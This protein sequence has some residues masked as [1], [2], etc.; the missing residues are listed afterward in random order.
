MSNSSFGFHSKKT[1]HERVCWHGSF[2]PPKGVNHRILIYK[3]RALGLNQIAINWFV[4][5]LRDREQIVDI[6]G[7]YSQ[8][9]N[10]TCGVPQRSI[11]GRLLFLIYV[12]D[13]KAAVKCKLI[14]YADD[15]VL[16]VSGKDVVKIE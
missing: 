2:R 4:S 6:A 10:I 3:L 16:L 8:A 11:L 15:F 5:Y 7:T 12:N 9:C 1:G 13:M 14:L